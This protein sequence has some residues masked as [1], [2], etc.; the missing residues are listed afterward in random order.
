LE[1]KIVYIADLDQD[2]DD[3]IAILYLHKRGVLK[4]VVCDPYPKDKEGFERKEK[5]EKLG[6]NIQRKMPPVAKYVFVSGAL[7]LVA[8]YIR[9]H[10]IDWLVMNGGFVGSNIVKPGQELKKFKGKEAVRTFNFNCD[11]VATNQVLKSNGKQIGHIVLVG[12]NVC[13]DARNTR[14]GIW[15]D[16]EYQE[17]FELYPVKDSKLQHDLLACH[18]GLAFLNEAGKF[19]EY[20]VVRPYNTGL[21]GKFTLWGSTKN[22]NT[23]Y[24][25]VLAAVGYAE[26][27]K[28]KE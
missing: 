16:S 21:N 9:I 12:K 3:I 11:V 13:H 27:V 4:C 1:R 24:R 18:E 26:G 14:T 23:P 5:L 2:I 22:G 28:E 7:T 25:E 15:K 10:R 8:R 19:C 17:I 20:E 6:I